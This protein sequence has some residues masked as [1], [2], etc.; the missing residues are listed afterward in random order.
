MVPP[1]SLFQD[2]FPLPRYKLG[3]V[4]LHA[5][6]HTHLCMDRWVQTFKIRYENAS[7]FQIQRMIRTLLSPLRKTWWVASQD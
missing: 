1:H 7:N 5:Q 6:D 3:C 2:H 4:H